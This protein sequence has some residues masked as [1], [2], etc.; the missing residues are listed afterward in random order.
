MA[1]VSH[2]PSGELY[3]PY[4]PKGEKY[5][6]KKQHSFTNVL[7]DIKSREECLVDGYLLFSLLFREQKD[8]TI[9]K[10]DHLWS[11]NNQCKIIFSHFLNLNENTLDGKNFIDPRLKTIVTNFNFTKTIQI[12]AAMTKIFVYD[13]GFMQDLKRLKYATSDM[14][15]YINADGKASL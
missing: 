4:S 13:V 12:N 3:F 1:E 11:E 2:N 15:Q 14:T 8:T 9:T 10:V 6:R 7:L 5:E